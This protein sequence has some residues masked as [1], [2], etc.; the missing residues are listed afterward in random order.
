M[1]IRCPTCNGS[2][3]AYVEWKTNTCDEYYCYNCDD[4]FIVFG[5]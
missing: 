1:K 3:I 5:E 2:H 4:F